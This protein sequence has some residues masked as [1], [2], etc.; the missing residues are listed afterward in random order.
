ME[1]EW[2]G[3][4]F[5]KEE[6]KITRVDQIRLAKTIKV[7]SLNMDNVVSVH[8]GWITEEIMSFKSGQDKDVKRYKL[9]DRSKHK[10]NIEE[11][12]ESRG[13]SEADPYSVEP[14]DLH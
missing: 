4:E 3:C 9:G 13:L 7:K 10:F 14:Q 1:V 5:I 8:S 2:L 12:F 6:T 11:L